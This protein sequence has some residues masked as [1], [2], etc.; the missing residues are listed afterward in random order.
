[1]AETLLFLPAQNSRHQLGLP[2]PQKA[3][4]SERAKSHLTS[5]ISSLHAH[6]YGAHFGPVTAQP[7]LYRYLFS[8]L[9]RRD[10]TEVELG[11]T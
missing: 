5:F 10:I 2:F 1:M 8:L 3:L 4:K 11:T 6:E 9:A 7:N